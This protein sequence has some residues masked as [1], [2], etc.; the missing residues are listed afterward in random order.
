M[1]FIYLSHRFT[2]LVQDEARL[3]EYLTAEPDLVHRVD[4]WDRTLLMHAC[5]D[6]RVGND[7]VIVET[8]VLMGADP[9]QSTTLGTAFGMC[10]S[11]GHVDIAN[12]LARVYTNT[13]IINSTANNT[14][15]QRR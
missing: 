5:S 10:A 6:A 1:E 4:E 8:L 11:H 15:R 9:M 7:L 12:Y 13:V 14:K 2:W 3:H